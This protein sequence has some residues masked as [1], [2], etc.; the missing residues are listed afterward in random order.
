[1]L[2]KG[3]SVCLL[4]EYLRPSPKLV[5]TYYVIEFVLRQHRIVVS[6]L[7]SEY[8]HFDPQVLDTYFVEI[9]ELST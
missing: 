1:M 7:G 9:V 5:S 3:V 8:P 6:T 4:T 2:S